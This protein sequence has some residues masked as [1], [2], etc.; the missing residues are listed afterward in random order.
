MVEG[1]VKPDVV[2]YNDA[3]MG[4]GRGGRGELMLSWYKMMVEKDGLRPDNTTY[5]TMI[6]GLTRN[7]M[8][9]E[10][11]EVLQA[12]LM[13]QHES[14]S[15]RVYTAGLE[16]YASSGDVRGG[17][18]LVRTMRMRDRLLPTGRMKDALVVAAAKGG[19]WSQVMTVVR[20]RLKAGEEVGEMMV[21]VARIMAKEKR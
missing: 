14:L 5:T 1:G 12:A 15:I 4:V 10:A 2:C 17:E 8:R 18:G 7:G 6:E 16:A 9:K 13:D 20:G 11:I 19:Q 21:S 3:I